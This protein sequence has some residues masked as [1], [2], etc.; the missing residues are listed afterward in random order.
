MTPA[1][2]PGERRYSQWAGEPKGRAEKLDKCVEQITPRG[3]Y[4]P[5]QCHRYRG[6]GPNG[7]YCGQHAKHYEGK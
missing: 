4:I 5:H 2:K 6:H 3:S 7:E 1:G